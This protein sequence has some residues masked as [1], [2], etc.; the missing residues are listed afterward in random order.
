MHLVLWSGDKPREIGIRLLLAHD[1]S[2]GHTYRE[3]GRSPHF[4]GTSETTPCDLARHVY[5]TYALSKGTMQGCRVI[6]IDS[7]KRKNQAG[8]DIS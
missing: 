1:H 2:Y 8:V 3:S 7:V 4:R 6:L 5:E